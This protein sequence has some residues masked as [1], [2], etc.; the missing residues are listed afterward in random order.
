MK[1]SSKLLIR[2]MIF[3]SAVVFFALLISACQAEPPAPPKINLEEISLE[4]RG[5]PQRGL[6]ELVPDD[7]SAP[8]LPENPT[9][10][11]LGEEPYY[12]ICLACHG[13]WGQGLTDEWRETGFGEDMNC[14]QSKC[15]ASNHPPQGFIFPREVPPVLGKGA[16]SGISSADQLHQVI[17]ETMPWWFPGSL[18]DEEAINLTAYIMRA[19][20]ELPEGIVL[21]EDNMAAFPL[22]SPAGEIVDDEPGGIILIAGLSVAMLAYVWTIRFPDKREES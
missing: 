10:A 13:N 18:S 5:Y 14:W 21:T 12:Q 2:L 19:R 7:L 4:K 15:H 11:D 9:Q 22:H 3:G 8:T 20:G 6:I 17:I 1:N 16:M